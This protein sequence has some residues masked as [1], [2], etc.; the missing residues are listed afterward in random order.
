[1]TIQ[2]AYVKGLDDAEA[3]VM[4]VIEQILKGENVDVV[5]NPKL[6]TLVDI[7]QIRSDYYRSLSVRNN[8]IGKIFRK[9]VKEQAEII[10][11]SKE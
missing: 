5:Q 3:N 2:E 4:R 7:V 11:K 6:K 8:N 10:D 1:M 9:R